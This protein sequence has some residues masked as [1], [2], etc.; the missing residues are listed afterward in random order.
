MKTLVV[1]LGVGKGTWGKVRRI[2]GE[3]WEKIVFIGNQWAHDTFKTDSNSEWIILDD[4]KDICQMVED[5]KTTIGDDMDDIY[6][7]LLSGSGKEHNAV[8]AAFAQANKSYKV[9][10]V[11][12]DG[13]KIYGE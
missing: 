10:C 12:D 8:L 11:C 6:I 5:I 3:E 7:N 4:Q 2:V 1:T 13:I 9:V